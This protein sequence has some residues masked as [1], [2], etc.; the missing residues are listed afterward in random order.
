MFDLQ[1]YLRD[2]RRRVDAALAAELPPEHASPAPLHRAMRYAVFSGGKR[3][4][5]VLCLAA[6][7]AAGAEPDTARLP[8]VAI[9]LLHTYTLIHDDLPGM[10]DDALRRGKATCHVVFGEA[11]AVLAGDALQALAFGVAARARVPRPYPP[12][13]L[14]RELARA[15]GSRGVVA[16]QVEDLA[17]PD[18]PVDVRRIRRVHL[19]K[20]A[21]LFR[22]AVRMG[23]IAGGARPA[24]LRAL[25]SYAV[26]VGLAFQIA[27]DLLDAVPDGPE[28][29]APADGTSC[30]LV[31]SPETAQREARRLTRSAVAALAAVRVNTAPLA[32][33][34][35]FLLDRRE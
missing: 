5:P 27:A 25:T 7:D 12:N 34:A 10:D 24:E 18:A 26:R 3:L 32:A 31:W 30:L 13:A 1:A 23:A 8:A 14:V 17:F 4:R 22:A 11:N 2:R 9:E 35:T 21:S 19:R 33:L 28:P 16:G 29:P 6:A 20:T 15:A